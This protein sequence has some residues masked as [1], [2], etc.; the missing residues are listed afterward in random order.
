M[1]GERKMKY[2][3]AGGLRER[4]RS[5]E[6]WA[7]LDVREEGDF[8]DGHLLTASCLPLSRL[9]V[10]IADMVPRQETP[11]VLCGGNGLM[12]RAADRLEQLGYTNVAALPGGLAEWKAA[13]LE[14]YTGIF[15][16]SKAFGEFVEAS[17]ETPHVEAKELKVR[18][19]AGEDLLVVDS[20][21]L[22]EYRTRNIPGAIDVPGVELVYRI[23]DLVKSDSTLV[24]VNCG[25]RTRSIIGAQSLINA[26]LENRVVAL[27]NGTM[28][29][30]L[31]GYPL[32]YGQT[33]R[34]GMPS[35]LSLEWSRTAA[36][37][38]GARFAIQ[39]IDKSTLRAWRTDS[40]RTVYLIDIRQPEE[41]EEGHLPGSRHV[42]GGQLVQETDRYLPVRNA[43]IVLVDGDGVR[44]TVA[45]SWLRQMGF[46]DV[47][48][49]KDGLSE[50][51][52]EKGRWKPHVL[53]LRDLAVPEIQAGT[54]RGMDSRSD[55]VVIDL[56]LSTNYR[57]GHIPGAWFG[58][59]SQLAETLAAI[60]DTGQV[61][62]TSEDGALARLAAADAVGKCRLPVHALAGGNE[63]WTAA[64][65]EIESSAH[66]WAVPPRDIWLKPFDQLQG[67][68][69]DRL[70]A[71][72]TWEVDLLQQVKRDGSVR[73]DFAPLEVGRATP[74]ERAVAK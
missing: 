73:F 66:R 41:Y 55:F 74:R 52:L 9:E 72:L 71:Y 28:G 10:L 40:A 39:K 67:K 59:R 56:S 31:A 68:V 16:P 33:R 42:Q 8:A 69:E 19:D 5:G 20:R 13:G 46:A 48:V 27:K 47:H 61:I 38:I 23:R 18:M 50:I 3:S 36:E 57:R 24:V 62:L 11:L 45:A 21:P 25:G 29:W 4:F 60:G 22:D 70:N 53:G 12:E 15:V 32:E 49:L 43:R 65:G 1:S 17:Y 34:A 2:L 51:P 63:A 14:T 37:R 7:L 35:A 44:A 26:G 58:V 54:L 64:G 6:E 30:H